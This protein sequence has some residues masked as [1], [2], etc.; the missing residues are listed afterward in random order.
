[1]P[2][3]QS[4]LAVTGQFNSTLPHQTAHLLLLEPEERQCVTHITCPALHPALPSEQ[5]KLSY[6]TNTLLAESCL[7]HQQKPREGRLTTPS[8]LLKP[9]SPHSGCYQ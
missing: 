7:P 2:P 6:S 3:Q 8:S 4:P 1:M 9:E 5:E